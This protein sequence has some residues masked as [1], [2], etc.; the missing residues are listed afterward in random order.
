MRQPMD[1][2]A[3]NERLSDYFFGFIRYCYNSKANF[4]F[5]KLIHKI[6]EGAVRSLITELAESLL[7]QFDDYFPEQQF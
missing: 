6:F 2:S 3:V 5:R 4:F 1:S 7:N